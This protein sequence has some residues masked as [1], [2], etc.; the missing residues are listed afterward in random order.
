MA[1]EATAGLWMAW[2]E[3]G[4]EGKLTTKPFEDREGSEAVWC[5]MGQR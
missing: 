4:D 2:G 1:L 3:K 5:S